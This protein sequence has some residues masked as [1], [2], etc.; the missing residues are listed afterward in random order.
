MA[1][2]LDDLRDNGAK[3]YLQDG[4]FNLDEVGAYDRLREATA[5]LINYVNARYPQ[6]DGSDLIPYNDQNSALDL[7]LALDEHSDKLAP[8]I[9]SDGS[10]DLGRLTQDFDQLQLEALERTKAAREAASAEF[11]REAALANG[12]GSEPHLEGAETDTPDAEPR[13]LEGAETDAPNAEPRHLEGAETDAP[14]APA[15]APTPSLEDR[16]RA[17]EEQ[18]R[19]TTAERDA[20]Q[21][22]NAALRQDAAAVTPTPVQEPAPQPA[23]ATPTPSAETS[24]PPATTTHTPTGQSSVTPVPEPA[25]TPAPQTDAAAPVPAAVTPP[26]PVQPSAPAAVAPAP[27]HTEAGKKLLDSLGKLLDGNGKNDIAAL[28]EALKTLKDAGFDLATVDPALN[29]AIE[30]ATDKEF[31]TT[32]TATQI[33]PAVSNAIKEA[34]AGDKSIDTSEIQKIGTA[35]AGALKA[36]GNKAIVTD[37]ANK[38]DDVPAPAAGAV[39]AAKLAMKDAQEA[40]R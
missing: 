15:T 32:R 39:D 5:A 13:H 28:K 6:P 33:L 21:R 1:N 29:A 16:V 30:K 27:N 12:I 10:L 7:R 18:L 31:V 37:V 2:I 20:L 4:K 40:F 23:P 19:V 34:L 25:P 35:L 26:A 22:E 11:A 14:D 8:L 9:T 36:G 38:V 17:L 3:I 24:A